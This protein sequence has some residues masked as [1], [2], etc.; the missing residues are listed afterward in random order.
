M[1][2]HPSESNKVQENIEAEMQQRTTNESNNQRDGSIAS[3]MPQP[4]EEVP[5]RHAETPNVTPDQQRTTMPIQES[6]LE[7][8]LKN[9]AELNESQQA[10]LRYLLN[11]SDAA[12]SD[13]LSELS[14]TGRKRRLSTSESVVSQSI[15]MTRLRI[16]PP[17]KYDGKDR[18][19]A[20]DFMQ[21]VEHYFRLTEDQL[22]NE[23]YKIDLFGTFLKDAA[24]DWYVNYVGTAEYLNKPSWVLIREKFRAS[25]ASS[26]VSYTHLR[27]H[28]TLS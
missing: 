5:L 7:G 14:L 12:V 25:F 21:Q 19:V 4:P 16:T 15:R 26:P 27:A 18:K 20:E 28:E 6:K 1:I 11:H 8:L 13:Q 22:P 3:E 9:I 17:E 2:I 10:Q 24:W 23:A